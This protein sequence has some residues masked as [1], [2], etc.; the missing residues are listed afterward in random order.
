MELLDG[1]PFPHKKFKKLTKSIL[2]L[3]NNYML[4]MCK[5]LHEE[6]ISFPK[7]DED[8]SQHFEDREGYNDMHTIVTG[9]AIDMMTDFNRVKNKWKTEL[10]R[11]FPDYNIIMVNYIGPD[12]D[13]LDKTFECIYCLKNTRKMI[14]VF[15][16]YVWLHYL[17]I[18]YYD[19]FVKKRYKHKKIASNRPRCCF[20]I[21]DGKQSENDMNSQVSLAL[22]EGSLEQTIK[23]QKEAFAGEN[24]C[25]V[26]LENI[27]DDDKYQTNNVLA[28]CQYCSTIVCKECIYET[29]LDKHNQCIVCKQDF[30]E[31]FE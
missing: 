1:K 26:C 2:T 21:Y 23:A 12:I 4:T 25:A 24:F 11:H 13:K 7:L 15:L 17:Q 27:D 19:K 16:G 8:Y 10:Q 18:N 28:Q 22:F 3:P 20:M 6:K 5:V 29:G 9:L 30:L 14:V 31:E